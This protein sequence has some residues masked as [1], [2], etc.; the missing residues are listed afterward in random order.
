M[1]AAAAEQV[2][3]SVLNAS[4]QKCWKARDAFFGCLDSN[5][6]NASKCTRAKNAFE[7]ECPASWV[8]HFELRRQQEA[9][10]QEFIRKHQE[11]ERAKRLAEE[12]KAAQAA[13]PAK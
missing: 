8:K 2:N 5:S 6:V 10:R 13:A 9:Q 1:S 4:R 3:E 11:A 12:Q 7:K